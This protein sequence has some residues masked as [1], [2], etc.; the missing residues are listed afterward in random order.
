MSRRL[1]EFLTVG[2]TPAEVAALYDR[3]VAAAS[4][5]GTGVCSGRF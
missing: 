5:R 1:D 4:E 3:A 2:P